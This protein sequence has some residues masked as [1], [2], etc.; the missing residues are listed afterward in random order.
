M[1]VK[2]TKLA[3][4]DEATFKSGDLSS[5]KLGQMNYGVSLPLDYYL[6]GDMSHYPKIGE[7]VVV[8]RDSRNGVKSLGLFKSSP[9]TE[10][11]NQ[12]FKTDN[13]VYQLERI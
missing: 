8:F 10:I 9:V 2:L 6:E 11:S 1:R 3:E 13:S 12:F 7:P 5:Y 4:L